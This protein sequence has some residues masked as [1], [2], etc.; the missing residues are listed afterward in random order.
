MRQRFFLLLT[1]S[2]LGACSSQD[3]RTASREPAGIAPDP[4]RTPEAV[5][6]VY[7][8]RAFNWRGVFGVHSWVAMKPKDAKEFTSVEV[9]GW[10]TYRGLNTVSQHEGAPDRRWFGADPVLLA[11]LRGPEAEAAIPRIAAAAA[12]Y[13][14]PDTYWIWPGPNSNSFVAHLARQAPELRLDL[15]PTA[16]GKDF[17]PEGGF[18]AILPSGT[19]GQLSLYGLLGA[20]AGL[21]EGIE[22]N[23]LGLVFGIDP[24]DLA[25]KLPLAGSL[26]LGPLIKSNASSAN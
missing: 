11:D 2:L 18:A 3:W 1:L 22:I 25:I 5:V 6:Q 8:A 21:E 7:A 16:I 15:P 24:N 12:S 4:A 26:G 13:P 20:G 23:L 17:L 10:N 19:G 9:L 14:Y